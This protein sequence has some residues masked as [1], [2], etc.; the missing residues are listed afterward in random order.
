M[1]SKIMPERPEARPLGDG[2]RPS[3]EAAPSVLREDESSWPRTCG[4]VGSLL[5]TFGG[6]LLLIN[7]YWR[8]VRINVTWAGFCM[9]AGL[10]G[11]LYHAAFE[12][13]VRLRRLYLVFGVLLLVVGTFL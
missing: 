10:A 12:R 6:A 5:L 1:S 7:L 3:A 9:V 11:M 8:S 13:D 4:L 2:W